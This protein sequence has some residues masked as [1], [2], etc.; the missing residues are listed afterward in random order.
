LGSYS[1]TM[2]QQG[3]INKPLNFDNFV[4]LE[5]QGDFVG[6]KFLGMEGWLRKTQVFAV[7]TPNASR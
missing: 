3:R 4:F 5:F 7:S 2:A 1:P 6:D